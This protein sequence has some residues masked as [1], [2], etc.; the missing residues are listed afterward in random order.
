MCSG[1]VLFYMFVK[2]RQT[3]KTVEQLTN[4]YGSVRIF[5]CLKKLPSIVSLCS[6]TLFKGGKHFFLKLFF[7][8]LTEF[9]QLYLFGN[10]IPFYRFIGILLLLHFVLQ[11]RFESKGFHQ[12]SI[13]LSFTLSLSLSLSLSFSLSLKR[14][15]R[16]EQTHTLERDSEKGLWLFFRIGMNN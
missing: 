7:S 16:H 4:I 2:D 5:Y 9:L 8:R 11:K 12:K 1:C 14:T 13:S 3:D 10:N 15:H 6:F